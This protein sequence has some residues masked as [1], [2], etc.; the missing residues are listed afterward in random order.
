MRRGL[1]VILILFVFCSLPK[2]GACVPLVKLK[3]KIAGF[4]PA[5]ASGIPTSVKIF[6]IY[7]PEQSQSTELSGSA[8]YSFNVTPGPYAIVSTVWDAAGTS[9][10]NKVK[11]KV[12]QKKKRKN[13]DALTSRSL[14][15]AAP[16]DGPTISV[17]NIRWV[18][19]GGQP[20]LNYDQSP[21]RWD[22]IFLTDL[23]AVPRSCSFHVVEDR[24]F[25]L[26]NEILKE[27]KLQSSKF[28]DP[29]MRI[30]YK[31]ALRTL[32]LWAPL[33]RLTGSV[34]SSDDKFSNGATVNM[35]LIELASGKVKWQRSYSATGENFI[36]LSERVARDVERFIC[37]NELPSEIR[38]S[39]TSK[40]TIEPLGGVVEEYSGTI[41]FTLVD[42]DFWRAIPFPLG[43]NQYAPYVATSVSFIGNISGGSPC[44]FSGSLTDEFSVPLP[45]GVGG[46]LQLEVRPEDEQQRRY[47]IGVT[48]QAPRTSE[49]LLT[50][51]GSPPFSQTKFWNPSISS[52]GLGENPFR[53][54]DAEISGQYQTQVQQFTWSF[55]MIP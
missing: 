37:G 10:R 48:A 49:V 23:V 19:G 45:Q 52:P 50:C 15:A 47:S 44:T 51:S 31:K 4:T 41:T 24:E 22:S 6:N 13:R 38:G 8:S 30:N 28:I 3:G 11:I 39:Y 55:Q 17:G 32:D 12:V 26:Y 36:S 27:L 9:Y 20:Y 54:M 34:V 42:P 33:Y 35:Q 25:G 5:T 2:P 7:D 43:V 21:W 14:R 1:S 18:N 16:P 53:V 29:S 40:T 46:V